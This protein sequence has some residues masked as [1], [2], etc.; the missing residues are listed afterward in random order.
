M[1]TEHFDVAIIGGG[2]GGS[3]AAAILAEKGRRVVLFER[4][5]FPRFHIGESLLP[6]GW[7]LWE[8]LGVT[9]ELDREGFTI[10]QG[11]NF[12]ILNT[13][14]IQLLT[15]EFPQYFP[16]PYA[17]HVE[18]ARY[19]EILLDN[20]RR[21]GADVRQPWEVDDVLFEGTRAL[22]VVAGPVGGPR[23]EIRATVVVDASGRSC[24]L[25]RKLGWRKP[26]PALNK[27]SYYTHY[28]GAVRRE[29]NGTVMTD[30]HSFDGGWFWYIPLKNDVVSVGAVLDTEAVR[31][32]GASGVRERFELALD[33]CPRVKGWVADAERLMD[34]HTVSSIAY[35]N[36][37]FVGDGFVLIG[38][39]S[40]FV[41]PIFSAGVTLAMRGGIFA[42][43]T[44]HDA[45]AEGN[46]SAARLK[47][48]EDALRY[49]MSKIFRMI[50]NWYS[51]LQRKDADN[52]FIRSRRAPLLRERLIVLL[53]GGYDKVDMDAL[54]SNADS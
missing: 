49:P 35:L 1:T 25:A 6:A 38:D 23:T 50:Y 16:R 8:R 46:V 3:S 52:V 10:K 17:Y 13:A 37:S 29:T 28:R 15:G 47:A 53:S 40:C 30:I 26:D 41:D 5:P 22:G 11:I 24:M 32:M 31:A 36:D 51:I 9:A 4:E 34:F 44:I 42:A 27:L 21:K 7:E 12:G 20:A 39:A 14:D 48:Y 54:L 19:D 33:R 45:L 43:D 18:R 2:P